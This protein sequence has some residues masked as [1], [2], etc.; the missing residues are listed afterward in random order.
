MKT[1][2]ILAILTGLTFWASVHTNRNML[3][4]TARDVHNTVRDAIQ[5]KD[6]AITFKPVQ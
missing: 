2:V 4:V 1:T 5:V 6:G 3:D